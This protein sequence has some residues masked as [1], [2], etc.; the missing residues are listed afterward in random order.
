[1][2]T[3]TTMKRRDF[4]Q[5][6]IAATATTA[7]QGALAQG[8]RPAPIRLGMV[9]PITG[10]FASYGA[11]AVPGA[12]LAVKLVN[13]K[14]GIASLR[15]APLELIVTDS[16]GDTKVTVA[17]VD[18]LI[19]EEK[20]AGI[21][22][23]FSSLDALAANPLSDQYKIPFVSPFWSSDKAFTLNSRYSRTLNLTSGSYAS[24]AVNM[25]KALRAKHGLA[26]N[27]VALVWDS[28]EYGKGAA[29]AVRRHLEAL[30]ITPV[31][32]LPVTP[33]ATDY[34]PTILRI[35]DS[36]ADVV[37]PCFYFQEAV[38]LL[39]AADALNFRAPIIG[40]GSGFADMRLPGALGADVAA[41]AL[42]APVFGTTTGLRENSKYAPLQ[43]LLKAAEKEAI[44]PGHTPGV[45]LEWYG[46]AA[47]AIYVFKLGFEQAATTG[48]SNVNDVIAA[49]KVRRGSEWVVAPFY[50]PDLSWEPNGQPR[51]QVPSIAQWQDGKSVIVYP[52]DVA[53]A[54][55]RL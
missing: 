29:A 39:R 45:E 47:Q 33:G 44:R 36:G 6:S 13:E 11:S 4:M 7:W 15:G 41:R 51:N 49:M 37:I 19:N 8:G 34:T 35:R 40:C 26:A 3:K 43:G 12:Q 18:R 54:A 5:L 9:L 10:R 52:D 32:D 20:V 16:K 53:A 31:L 22:G 30:R 46:L 17:E 28:G 48:G 21:V 27:K 24:G 2:R 50:D 1:M 23:P 14:G 42:K 25:L 38:L 55:P